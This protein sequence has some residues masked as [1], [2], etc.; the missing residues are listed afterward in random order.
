MKFTG[1]IVQT[2]GGQHA[3]KVVISVSGSVIAEIG[4]PT[5]IAGDAMIRN[6][7]ESAEQMTLIR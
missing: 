1:L 3:Y 6:V 4:V 5:T 7:L 2:P